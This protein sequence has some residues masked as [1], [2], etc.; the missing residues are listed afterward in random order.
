M[1]VAL[2]LLSFLKGLST[3]GMKNSNSLTGD[4]EA[5]AGVFFEGGRSEQAADFGPDSGESDIKSP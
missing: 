4:P 3:S 5:R 2:N 1:L